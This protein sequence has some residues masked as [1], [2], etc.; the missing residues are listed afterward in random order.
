MA[1]RTGG[2]AE[3]VVHASDQL[4]IGLPAVIVADR[5]SGDDSL[6]VFKEAE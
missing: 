6:F 5:E 2:L 3:I 1:G 4:T